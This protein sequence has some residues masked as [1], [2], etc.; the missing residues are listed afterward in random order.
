VIGCVY[1]YPARS[2]GMRRARAFRG[3]RETR[4]R[5]GRA[6]SWRACERLAPLR[7]ARFR[8]AEYASRG[9]DGVNQ[10]VELRRFQCWTRWNAS[11]CFGRDEVTVVVVPGSRSRPQLTWPVKGGTRCRSRGTTG[12]SRCPCR[13]RFVSSAEKPIG[14]VASRRPSPTWLPSDEERDR[15]ALGESSARRRRTPP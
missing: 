8:N 1:I 11:C 10:G 14:I 15:C 13:R 3:S 9:R 4:R 12:V 7:L 2:G 5:P 6:N